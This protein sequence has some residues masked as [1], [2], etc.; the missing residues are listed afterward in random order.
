MAGN[1]F[2]RLQ[3]NCT[4][5]IIEFPLHME[6]WGHITLLKMGDCQGLSTGSVSGSH[7][8]VIGDLSF[9]VS[10]L[11][12]KRRWR[13]PMPFGTLMVQILFTIN[14]L[15]ILPDAVSC[16]LFRNSTFNR[17]YTLNEFEMDSD[18]HQYRKWPLTNESN[19]GKIVRQIGDSRNIY[20]EWYKL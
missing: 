11:N 2:W 19:I 8:T 20:S 10:F 12:T 18:S 7:D 3:K 13:F 5:K 6:T 15:V 14:S 16:L 9:V 17:F 4:R 1:K